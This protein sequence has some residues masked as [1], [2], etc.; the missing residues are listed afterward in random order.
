[1]DRFSE[2]FSSIIIN[3]MVFAKPKFPEKKFETKLPKTKGFHNVL[4]PA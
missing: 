1:M 2:G 4:F 3:F